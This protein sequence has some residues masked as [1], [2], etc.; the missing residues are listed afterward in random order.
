M[1]IL[2]AI[3]VFA[4]AAGGLAAGLALTG[5]PPRTACDGA[6]CHGGGACAG[7][8]NRREPGDG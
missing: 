5:R 7:C 6:A 1:E 2:L 4:L 3:L 8:P